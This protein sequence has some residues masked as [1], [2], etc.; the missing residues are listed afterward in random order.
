MLTIPK[1]LREYFLHDRRRLELLSRVASRT[2]HA[3]VGAALG[4][5]DAVPRVISLAQSF[6]A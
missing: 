5:A 1:R 3:Y 4:E 2:L 6:G